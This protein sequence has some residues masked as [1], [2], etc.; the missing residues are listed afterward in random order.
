MKK[1]GSLSISKN[2]K[3][4]DSGRNEELI[5]AAEFIVSDAL[6]AF[7]FYRSII[8]FLIFL[9][10]YLKYRKFRRAAFDEKRK[11]ELSAE[12]R[13]SILSVSNALNAG[14]SVENAFIEAYGD[15]LG[16]YGEDAVIVK[17]YRIIAKRLKNNESIE[18]IMSDFAS[19]S[20]IEDISDFADVFAAAKRSGGDMTKIIKRAASNISDKI[21]V[22]REIDTLMSSK[23]Y[24]QRIMEVVPFAIIGYLGI[25]SPG[26]LDILYHNVTGIAVM[27]VCLILYASGFVLAE[28]IISIEV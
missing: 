26:F 20:G 4:A 17:E 25:A 12:F 9:P 19:R 21:D 13:E 23:K 5:V 2:F 6:V 8:P 24:E 18:L 16:M 11:K 14:Y 15:M 7:I 27:T 1:E 3:K 10:L 28:K 22:K